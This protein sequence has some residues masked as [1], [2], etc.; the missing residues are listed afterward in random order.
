MSKISKYRSLGPTGTRADKR[1]NSE[2]IIITP[3]RLTY[4]WRVKLWK[5]YFGIAYKT[6][7]RLRHFCRSQGTEEG[8]NDVKITRLNKVNL[9]YNICELTSACSG[10]CLTW[11]TT[12]TKVLSFLLTIS[13]LPRHALVR[14]MVVWHAVGC[15]TVKPR[16]ERCEVGYE[17]TVNTPPNWLPKVNE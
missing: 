5:S 9:S 13:Y 2:M 11:K 17:N 16:D 12:K 7:H 14:G 3:N 10:L 15:H 4:Q 1:N 8:S 6:F